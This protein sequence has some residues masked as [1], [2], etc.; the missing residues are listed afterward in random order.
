MV[1]FLFAAGGLRADQIEMQNG[2]RYAGKVVSM[3]A[4]TIV[5]QSD[6]LGKLTLPRNKVANINLGSLPAAAPATPPVVRTTNQPPA[7]SLTLSNGNPDI[8]AALRHLGANTNFVN[9]IRT[10]FLSDAGPEA[11]GKFDELWGGLLSGKLDMNGLRAEAKSA[12]DQIRALKKQGA[13]VGE[14]LD[15]YLAILDNFLKQTAPAAAPK[16]NNAPGATIIQ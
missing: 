4:D 15:S 11:N 5:L 1:L 8:S 2:D 7:A 9:Q 3:T 12:A 14:P 16:T 13:D 6:V 10:K